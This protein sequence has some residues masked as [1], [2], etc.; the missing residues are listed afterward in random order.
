MVVAV[1]RTLIQE[2]VLTNTRTLI[3]LAA[4]IA[5]LLLLSIVVEMR[6]KE[7][8]IDEL[9]VEVLANSFPIPPMSAALPKT[10]TKLAVEN[11]RD[12]NG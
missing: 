1:A 5:L 4:P 7:P 2:S 10:Q 9:E 8:E 3:I 12:S 11:V 6:K